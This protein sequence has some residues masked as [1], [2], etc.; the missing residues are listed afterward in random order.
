MTEQPEEERRTEQAAQAPEQ[1]AAKQA[2]ER[3]RD[4][5]AACKVQS[6][7]A[8]FLHRKWRAATGCG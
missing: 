8:G 4:A 7:V 1:Q 6:E 3:Q 2:A 5:E